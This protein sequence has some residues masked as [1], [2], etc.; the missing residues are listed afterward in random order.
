[1]MMLT[2]AQTIPAAHTLKSKAEIQLK[3]YYGL[4]QKYCVKS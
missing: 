4:K 3:C 2:V 1:M